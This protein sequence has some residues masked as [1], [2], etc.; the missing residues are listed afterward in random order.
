MKLS[1]LKEVEI[2]SAVQAAA[3]NGRVDPSFPSHVGSVI[4]V[5]TSWRGSNKVNRDAA[6][7]FQVLRLGAS[8]IAQKGETE[9]NCCA[10]I[11]VNI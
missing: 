9:K 7:T 2:D 6:Q 1:G 8:N 10:E 3:Q 5:K 11:L 4:N